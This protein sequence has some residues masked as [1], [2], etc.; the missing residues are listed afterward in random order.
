MACS[1]WKMMEQLDQTEDIKM[2]TIVK[3]GTHGYSHGIHMDGFDY[4]TFTVDNENYVVFKCE[5]GLRFG[6]ISHGRTHQA[7][8]PESPTPQWVYGFRWV[9]TE[10]TVSTRVKRFLPQLEDLL[11]NMKVIK[12]GDGVVADD[13]H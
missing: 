3:L 2:S 7:V 6:N 11:K 9:E 5:D 4:E 13:L 1:T 10:R 12:L 8:I